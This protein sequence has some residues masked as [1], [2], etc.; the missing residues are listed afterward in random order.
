MN[1]K[2]LVL[3][4][5]LV[6][7]VWLL[8]TC[9]PASAPSG[10]NCQQGIC[11]DMQLS[12]PIRFNEPIMATITIETEED[13]PKLSVALASQYSVLVEGTRAW[14]VDAKAHQQ[15]VFTGTVRFT[16][17][18]YFSVIAGVKTTLSEYV[19]DYEDVYVT[20]AGGTVS[21]PVPT[22]RSQA[23]PQ[24]TLSPSESPLPTPSPLKNSLIP[25]STGQ[26]IVFTTQ[27]FEG[28]FPDHLEVK[29]MRVGEGTRI[30]ARIPFK[31]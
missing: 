3:P 7:T 10:T 12:E 11:V 30:R 9:A 13:I 1:H 17:E 16:H 2:L 19:Q 23:V 27:D 29:S 24:P 20:R 21:T 15:L 28:K 6:V 25:H 26:W 5:V 8:T 14:E 31:V 22:G 18:G 4:V